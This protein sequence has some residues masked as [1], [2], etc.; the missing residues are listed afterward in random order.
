MLV[1]ERRTDPARQYSIF[2]YIPSRG[3][4]TIIA[5]KSIRLWKG[6]SEFCMQLRDAVGYLNC[7]PALSLRVNQHPATNPH[8]HI[9]KSI[10]CTSRPAEAWQ[11]AGSQQAMDYYSPEVLAETPI[12]AVMRYQ[13]FAKQNP[14]PTPPPYPS[15][16][17][18][19]VTV[20]LS[21]PWTAAF[22]YA[23]RG[24]YVCSVMVTL[25]LSSISIYAC[26]NVSLHTGAWTCGRRHFWRR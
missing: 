25:G 14:P 6:P 2:L 12:I 11:A 9:S 5:T 3:I 23:P 16:G 8:E 20:M 21:F 10:V 13:L 22:G 7:V 26:C 19:H 17:S 4:T 24:R 15:L 18:N 1:N